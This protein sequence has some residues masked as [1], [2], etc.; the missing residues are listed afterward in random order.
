MRPPTCQRAGSAGSAGCRAQAGARSRHSPLTTCCRP[1]HTPHLRRSKL[2]RTLSSQQKSVS[3][4]RFSHD[5]IDVASRGLHFW[6]PDVPHHTSSA[7]RAHSPP[8]N[9]TPSRAHPPH[10]P[11]P[12]QM[13]KQGDVFFS[14]WE[15]Q[16]HQR[17][18]P[19]LRLP[20]PRGVVQHTS[21]L[22]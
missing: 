18:L 21:A 8:P 10:P 3:R 2:R 1:Q 6:R 4:Y 19:L 16:M 12:K 9:H 14:M 15:G 7:S 20:R 5:V 17:R 13:T 11:H 22:N